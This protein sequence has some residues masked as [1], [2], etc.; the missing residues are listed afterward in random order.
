MPAVDNAPLVS[1]IMN[2]HNGERYLNEAIDS[3]YSQTYKTWEIIFWDNA[4]TDRSAEIAKSYDHRLRYFRSEAK[5]NLY[6]A[7]NFALKNARG[8]FIAILDTD[9][10]WMAEKL[11][12]QIPLFKDDQVGIVFSDA[13]YF[14]NKGQTKQLYKTRPYYTGWCFRQ[15]LKDYF[16]CLQSVV[17]RR[18]AV[19]ELDEMFDPRFNI[20]GDTDMFRRIA[21]DWKL[22]MINEPLVRYRIHS[23]SLVATRIDLLINEMDM[24]IEKYR[25]M[26]SDFEEKYKEEVTCMVR[27][28]HIL[29]ALISLKKGE[30]EKARSLAR[31]YIPSSRRILGL[32]LLT[33]FPQAFINL[34]LKIREWQDPLRSQ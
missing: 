5:A 18:K 33:F 34:V 3:A 13:I 20:A 29:D 17:I 10:L 14:N 12:R 1:I 28:C 9:D 30:P 22:E 6:E 16:I 15:L 21:Y 11:E 25:R 24:M 23:N 8:E 32:Y 4:S 26:Y 19:F 27:E 31:K 2:C 7:R